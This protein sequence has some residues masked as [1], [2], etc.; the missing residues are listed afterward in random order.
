M[1]GTRLLLN[2]QAYPKIPEF[3]ETKAGNV[4]KAK[5]EALHAGL[6]KIFSEQMIEKMESGAQ[7]RSWDDESISRGEELKKLMS[8]R[9]YDMLC[10]QGFPFPSS[11]RLI[12]TAQEKANMK[13]SLIAA[14]YP[15]GVID[16]ANYDVIFKRV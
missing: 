13:A 12:R 3:E 7:I 10:Q 2:D 1:A 5:Y 6:R 16:D 11:R 9:K 4:W 15:V 8:N 14:D